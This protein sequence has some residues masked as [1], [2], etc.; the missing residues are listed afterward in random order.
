MAK[1]RFTLQD[2]QK[3]GLSIVGERPEQTGNSKQVNKKILGA[4]KVE[5][6]GEKFASKLELYFYN[7]LKSSKIPFEFQKVITLQEKFKYNGASVREV[8]LIVDFYLPDHDI[9]ADTK[10]HQLADN[11]IKWKMLKRKYFLEGK[12]TKIYLPS[13]KSECDELVSKIIGFNN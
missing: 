11:K 13:K 3:K 12:Q 9:L 1:I 4:T 5:V 2:L 8:R 6:D 7:L 10:G